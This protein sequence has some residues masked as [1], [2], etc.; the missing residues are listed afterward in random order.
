[1]LSVKNPRPVDLSKSDFPHLGSWEN[2]R[3]A[4]LLSE[5]DSNEIIPMSNVT[6]VLATLKMF[7][8]IVI[9]IIYG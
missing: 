8:N 7:N 1:M 6:T 3:A 4:L 5:E 9:I 2:Y